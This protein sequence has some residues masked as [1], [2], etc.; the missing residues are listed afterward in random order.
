MENVIKSILNLNN[1]AENSNYNLSIYFLL[2]VDK[3]RMQKVFDNNRKIRTRKNIKKFSNKNLAENSIDTV[4][5]LEYTRTYH[6]S[7]Y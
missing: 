4:E 6:H 2:A 7:L 1:G 5:V 3:I